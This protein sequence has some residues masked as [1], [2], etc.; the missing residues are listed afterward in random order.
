MLIKLTEQQKTELQKYLMPENAYNLKT[1][2]ELETDEFWD[3]EWYFIVPS[4]DSWIKTT[5]DTEYPVS[6]QVYHL[7]QWWEID[8]V[9]EKLARK[10]LNHMFI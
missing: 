6:V 2:A 3:L 1:G 7:V 4:E 10:I 5:C 8:V 9:S